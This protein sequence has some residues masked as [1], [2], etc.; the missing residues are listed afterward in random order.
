MKFKMLYIINERKV[1]T[2]LG[3]YG[4]LKR[5]TEDSKSKKQSGEG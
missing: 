3:I 1:E 4:I 2:K 5:L